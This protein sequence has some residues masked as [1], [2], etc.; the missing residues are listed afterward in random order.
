[1]FLNRCATDVTLQM[2]SCFLIVWRKSVPWLRSATSITFPS[3]LL[4]LELV[5]REA[6]VQ[7][8]WDLAFVFIFGGEIVFRD[9]KYRI[10]FSN[11]SVGWCV[12]KPEKNGPGARSPPGGFRCDSGAGCDSEGAQCLPERH[13]PLVSCWWVMLW[14]WWLWSWLMITVIVTFVYR[15]RKLQHSLQTAEV[16]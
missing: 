8:R 12:L 9:I 13:R 16:C 15:A 7:W 11:C 1:M 4:V 14:W 5:W 2:W 10:A 3:S 6:L